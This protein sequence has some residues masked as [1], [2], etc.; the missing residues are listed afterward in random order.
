MD[1]KRTSLDTLSGSI[2]SHILEE[3]PRFYDFLAAYYEWANQQGNAKERIANHMDYL[4][5]SDSIDSYIDAMKQEYLVDTPEAVLLDKELFIKWSRKFNLTRGSR[6]SYQFLFKLLF[7]EQNI[8]LYLPKDNILKTSD[9]VWISG[10][11]LMLV[12][13]NDDNLEQFQFQQIEQ[14][15]PIYADIVETA[16]ASVQRVRTRYVGRYIATE[17]SIADIAGE[18]KPGFPINTQRSL[19]EWIVPIANNATIDNAGSGHQI[20]QRIY[21]DGMNINEVER[22]ADVNSL[23]DTR[24]TSFFTENDISVYVN[25]NLI[26]DYTYD[27]RVISSTSIN[28]G[29]L[30]VVEMPAYQGYIV[31]DQV[32][33]NQGI[34]S[35]DILDL[36]I[37]KPG[38]YNLSTDTT[39]SSFAGTISFGLSKPV[40]G[41]YTGTKGQLSSNMYIQDSYFYQNY[42]YTIRTEQDY[43][44]YADIVKRILHPSG[45]LMFGQL[46]Y[47]NIIELIL[48]YQDD[49]EIPNNIQTLL[50]KY[51]LGGN[52]NFINRF[53]DGASIRLY[54]QPFFDSL[55]QD[56][57]K[58]EVG[59]DLESKFLADR[60]SSY[61]YPNK[62]GWMSKSNASDYFL[63]VPQDYS[64]ETESGIQYFETGYVSQRTFQ[65]I[66]VVNFDTI[67]VS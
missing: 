25:S 22:I 30:V 40:K 44:E 57:L 13:Y 47:I 29:D 5:F 17:L 16:T 21:I 61:E 3:Y 37:G 39:G 1:N 60:V 33:E 11:S 23:F 36:P 10:E 41:Y 6:A 35:I 31:V 9:G 46:D 53:K 4:S 7:D 48:H 38:T 50:P 64:E 65:K 63:Y 28:I 43:D 58:G 52:Y 2:P 42:S 56:Y 19:T 26:N 67:I 55:D 27:G 34:K 54:R 18:F 45:F 51:G 32:D 59:Y 15:R 12:S 14:K 66:L 24:I 49:I 20:G 62:K 8:D